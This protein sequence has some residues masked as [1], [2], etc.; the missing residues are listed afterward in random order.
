MD[1][2]NMAAALKVSDNTDTTAEQTPQ[3]MAG[4]LLRQADLLRD[5]GSCAAEFWLAEQYEVTAR[6]LG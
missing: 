2:R 5:E 1:Y 3:G 4:E 6:L